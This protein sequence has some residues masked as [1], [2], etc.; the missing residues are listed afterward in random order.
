MVGGEAPSREPVERGEGACRRRR[1]LYRGGP[2]HGHSE[3]VLQAVR[4]IRALA[5]CARDWECPP[6]AR[7]ARAGRGGRRSHP[8][9]AGRRLHLYHAWWR[10]SACPRLTAIMECAEE[11]D[12]LGVPIIADG[13]IR[14]SGDIVKA[15][16]AG[17]SAVMLGNLLAGCEESPGEIEIYRNRAY[18]VSPADVV[19]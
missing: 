2:A 4:A 15:L 16:A 12:K 3:G 18:K 10:A 19:P 11:A 13:G 7:R 14:Y 17:A 6:R 1:G 8:C 5:R 9:G